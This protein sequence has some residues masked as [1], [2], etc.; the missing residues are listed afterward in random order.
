MRHLVPVSIHQVADP[1]EAIGAS[2]ARP[3]MAA[4]PPPSRPLI[5]IVAVVQDVLLDVAEI[6]SAGL[7]SGLRFGRLVQFSP[8]RRISDRV[9]CALDRMRR[10][11][12]Q[13]DPHPLTR[14]PPAYPPQEP[15]DVL[16]PLAGVEAPVD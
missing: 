5:G 2:I 11:A 16:G 8:S 14:I 7:S 4:D 10:V 9:T 13:G 12:V 1:H 6:V 15:A 3:Q